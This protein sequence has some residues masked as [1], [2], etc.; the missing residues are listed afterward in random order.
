[1]QGLN[2]DNN[3][4]YQPIELQWRQC[5]SA[6]PA[7]RGLTS[8]G[9]LD[10]RRIR[11]DAIH[12]L[13]RITSAIRNVRI[14]Y[15]QPAS[16]ISNLQ[17]RC[18]LIVVVTIVAILVGVVVFATVDRRTTSRWRRPCLDQ[19]ITSAPLD[20]KMMRLR[21][22]GCRVTPK[23]DVRFCGKDLTRLRGFYDLR[24]FWKGT[25]LSRISD[26]SR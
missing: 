2:E 23:S 25:K 8:H 13:T 11:I 18:W 4:I 3:F 16:V 1:M 10:R 22:V 7:G 20:V 5:N 14:K 12:S 24:W 26:S 17:S 19:T 9:N 6:A 15:R 21:R